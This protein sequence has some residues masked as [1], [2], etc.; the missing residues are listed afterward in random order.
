MPFL[1]PKKWSS[2]LPLA[3]WWYNTNYHTSLQCTPFEVLYGFPPPLI[4]EVMVLGPESPAADFLVQKQD[5]IS[6][7]KQN[8]AQA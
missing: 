3:E 1:R 2:W 8:L 6:K 5:M 7:L 4:S